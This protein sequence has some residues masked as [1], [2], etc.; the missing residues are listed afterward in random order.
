LSR[1][2]VSGRGKTTNAGH[3]VAFVPVLVLFRPC[4][5]FRLTQIQESVAGDPFVVVV[6]LSLHVA[7]VDVVQRQVESC[8]ASRH[9]RVV[10]GTAVGDAV[11][12][13]DAG[14][15]VGTYVGKWVG[16]SDVG[17]SVGLA[18]GAAVGA[19]VRAAE[20]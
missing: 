6:T 5:W 12:D 19:S 13:D 4:V 2:R 7:S 11:G 14:A 1:T 15:R 20:E 17:L 8:G 18:V 3:D 9:W 16:C 10:V